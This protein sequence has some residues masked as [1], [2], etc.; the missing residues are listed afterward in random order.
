MIMFLIQNSLHHECKD[1]DDSLA[2]NWSSCHRNCCEG[3]H[4]NTLHSRACLT[5]H[6][7]HQNGVDLYYLYFHYL[8]NDVR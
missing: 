7:L 4:D 8:G 2:S 3:P 6:Y 1:P 5:G